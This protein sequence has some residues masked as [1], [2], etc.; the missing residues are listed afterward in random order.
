[1]E[2]FI[3]CDMNKT[4]RDK[5]KSKIKYYGAFAAALSCIIYFANE[6]RKN[7]KLEGT[8]KLYR[9]LKLKEHEVDTYSQGSKINLMGFTSTTKSFTCA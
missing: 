8:T 5:E 1:M 9:G 6:N 7:N 4:S 3:Y 2:S